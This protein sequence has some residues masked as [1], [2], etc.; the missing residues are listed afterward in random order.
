MKLPKTFIPEKGLEEKVEDLKSQKHKA[1]SINDLVLWEDSDEFMSCK[2]LSDSN[3]KKA[4]PNIDFNSVCGNYC[5][6][7]SNVVL[8]ILEF[9]DSS[10]TENKKLMKKCLDSYNNSIILSNRYLVVKDN[11]AVFIHTFLDDHYNKS[12]FIN[13]YNKK[14]GFKELK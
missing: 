12:R 9:V 1:R 8:H 7:Y 6:K 3:L 4:Y 11:Y 13:A 2:I 10:Y 5:V 14:F